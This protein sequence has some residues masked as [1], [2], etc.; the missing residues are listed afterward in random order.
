M[1]TQEWIRLVTSDA[2]M[3]DFRK[4]VEHSAR[5]H[6]ATLKEGTQISTER[7]V[8]AIFPRVESDRSL[9]G[10]T[11]RTRIYVSLSKLATIGM[12]DCCVKGEVNG[13]FMGKPKRPWLWSCPPGGMNLCYACGQIVPPSEDGE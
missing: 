7:L 8:E 12:E 10:D 6:L 13:Q 11:A 2:P 4:A 9:A 5:L 3:R 1:K